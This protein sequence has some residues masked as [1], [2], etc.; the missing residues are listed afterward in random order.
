MS[1]YTLPDAT[2]LVYAAGKLKIP[3]TTGSTHSFEFP[4][5]DDDDNLDTEDLDN[6][7]RIS[8]R[9]QGKTELEFHCFM[10]KL[11]SHSTC[12]GWDKIQA[13]GDAIFV[14]VFIS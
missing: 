13:H 5:V 4:Y 8:C 6:E 7:E 1:L 12:T 9:E 11:W 2:V 14:I 3:L 10:C